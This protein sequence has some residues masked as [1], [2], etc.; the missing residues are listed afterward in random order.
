MRIWVMNKL[1]KLEET[2]KNDK[3]LYYNFFETNFF[4]IL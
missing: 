4:I 1:L 3:L 2:K